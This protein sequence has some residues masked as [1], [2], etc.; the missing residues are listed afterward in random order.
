M[1]SLLS[2]FIL[3]AL[4]A[5]FTPGPNNLMVAASGVNFGYRRSLPHLLGVIFGFPVLMLGVGFG[6]GEIAISNR[7]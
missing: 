3:F 6:L 5:G 1:S 2:A 4:V 7:A